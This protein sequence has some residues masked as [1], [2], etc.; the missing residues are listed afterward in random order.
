MFLILKMFSFNCPRG[1]KWI[2]F[3]HT[4]HMT[5]GDERISGISRSVKNGFWRCWR[6]RAAPVGLREPW[7]V[8]PRSC[9]CCLRSES[10][11]SRTKDHHI[12]THIY[13]WSPPALETQ[14]KALNCLFSLNAT[15][16]FILTLCSVFSPAP[17]LLLHFSTASCLGKSIDVRLDS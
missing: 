6:P 14:W 8:R 16:P 1:T 4:R 10:F 17:W 7:P 13:A 11:C 9:V 12:N 5:K 3:L 2:T 15:I